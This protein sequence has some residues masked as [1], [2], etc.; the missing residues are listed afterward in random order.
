MFNLWGRGLKQKR[1][2]CCKEVGVIWK[3]QANYLFHSVT[4]R[5]GSSA[6]RC[7][8]GFLPAQFDMSTTTLSLSQVRNLPVRMGSD[9][10]QAND[11][12][13][14]NALQRQWGHFTAPWVKAFFL[15]MQALHWKGPL[16][17]AG[18]KSNSTQQTPE[19]KDNT[20]QCSEAVGSPS[21]N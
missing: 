6:H 15:H 10:Q 20:N 8:P 19:D 4:L 16:S 17:R 18:L 21:V 12:Q 5:T 2:Q 13:L 9:S 3:P 1:M 7:S 14:V 11:L